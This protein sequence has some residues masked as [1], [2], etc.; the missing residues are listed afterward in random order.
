MR[1]AWKSERTLSLEDRIVRQAERLVREIVE[2]RDGEKRRNAEKRHRELVRKL[3]EMAHR[4]PMT[5]LQNRQGFEEKIAHIVKVAERN[6]DP[7]KTGGDKRRTD[8]Q[9]TVRYT[10]V[11]F[12]DIDKFKSINE[13][14]AAHPGGDRV[15]IGLAK[16]LESAF[17][18][19][20][21]VA[22]MGGDEFVVVLPGAPKSKLESTLE[23]IKKEFASTDFN[24]GGPCTPSFSFKV[25]EVGT[26]N[27][28][29][30]MIDEAMDR[31]DREVMD[32][33]R[34]RRNTE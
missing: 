17:R 10:A 19:T 15:I 14:P 6:D 25:H 21:I 18:D 28:L 29:K 20:D 27:D 8:D 5:G 1:K 4:D 22:R 2:A 16:L 31:A 3:A 30:E 32:M 34:R 11:A 26:G 23:R 13:L 9:R 12:I 33:K 24:L 7:R